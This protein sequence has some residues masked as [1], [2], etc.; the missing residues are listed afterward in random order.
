MTTILKATVLAILTLGCHQ[1]Y[2]DIEIEAKLIEASPDISVTTDLTPL[3]QLK[4]VDLLSAPR[5]AVKPGTKAKI[6]ITREFAIDG[7]EPIHVGIEL[8]ITPEQTPAGLS[9]IAKYK[10]T[11]FEG[12]GDTEGKRR[13]I[14]QTTTIP[15]NGSTQDNVPILIDAGSKHDTT[16]KRYIHLT[17]KKV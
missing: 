17:I 16:K 2:A 14:F 13:P 8:E 6:Q 3:N 7:Q 12:F 15:F 4:G 10:L 1:L 9:Y 11:E 5:V